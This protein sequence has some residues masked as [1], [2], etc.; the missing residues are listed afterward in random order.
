MNTED[1]IGSI[2]KEEKVPMSS[3]LWFTSDT[4][5]SHRNSMRYCGRPFLTVEA[6]D[7]AMI[8][9]WNEVVKPDDL[10]IHMGDVAMHTK[11]MERII[12]KLNGHK[13]LIIGNHDLIYHQYFLK[14]RGQKF[15]DRMMEIYKNV[16]FSK[17]FDSGKTIITSPTGDSPGLK[18]RLSHFPTKNAHDGYHN[19]KH[20][21]SRP[22]DDGTLN[23]CGHVHNS[24]L[25]RGNNIN[26]GVDVWDFRPVSLDDVIRLWKHGKKDIAN[27]YRTRV[28]FWKIYHT[29][30][31]KFKKLFKKDDKK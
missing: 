24:W 1:L 31:W 17:I 19:N 11:P 18:I 23:I 14:T 22:I 28:F 13:I 2:L 20:D 12:P 10:I 26:V 9:R 29:I 7:E 21:A 8:K 4:H 27:P 30:I 16:G 25:K 6:C 5:F 3:K 15:I